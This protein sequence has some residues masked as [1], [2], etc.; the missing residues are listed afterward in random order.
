[1]QLPGRG[2]PC[3]PT[4][5]TA[6]PRSAKP[7]PRSGK[8]SSVERHDSGADVQSESCS[9]TVPPSTK[10]SSTSS[11]TDAP[12]ASARQ[13]RPHAVQSTARS[14]IRRAASNPPTDSVPNGGRYHPGSTPVADAISSVARADVV[15]GR[16]RPEAQQ[17]AVLVAVHRDLVTGRGDVGGEARCLAHHVTEHEERGP[18]AELVERVEDCGV[19]LGSGPSSNVSATC[20][21]LPTPASDGEMWRPID[22]SA[23]SDGAVCSAADARRRR[24]RPRCRAARGGAGSLELRP[25]TRRE[26]GARSTTTPKSASATRSDSVSRSR[27]SST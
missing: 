20:P 25:A 26:P 4:G 21:G 22:E 17:R 16:A 3:S 5:P 2:M 24:P 19:E 9:S 7:F 6:R 12:V 27:P 18:P 1:M 13:S 11:T 15:V 8:A 10:P 14:P 23:T